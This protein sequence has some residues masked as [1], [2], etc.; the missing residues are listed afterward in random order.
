MKKFLPAILVLACLVVAAV[1]LLHRSKT[2]QRGPVEEPF[3]TEPQAVQA[4]V[5]FPEPPP[6]AV[7]F[8]MKYR[9]LSGDKDEFRYNSYY[10]YGRSGG[11]DAPFIKAVGKRA[12]ELQAVYNPQLKGAEWSAVELEDGKAVAFHFDLNA[13]GKV[14]D[15][16][17]I[18]PAIVEEEPIRR[19]EF[20]T[21]DFTTETEDGHK[22]PFRVL[23][24]AE[25]YGSS[26]S[27]SCMWSP[28][29]VL[30]G[31]S[32]ID[33]EPAKLILYTGGFSGSFT[34]FGR[35][36]YSLVIGEEE[37]GRHISRQTL[38]S[39]INHDGQFYHVDLY[40]RHG[41]DSAVRAVIR[42][43][44]G[45][46]GNLAVAL[47]SDSKLKSRLNGAGIEGSKDNTINFRVSTD[48]PVLPTGTYKLS[49]ANIEYGTEDTGQWWVGL[50][51]GPEFAVA[52][53]KRSTLEFGKP[54][55]SVR[56]VDEEKRY[57]SDVKEQ[58]TYSKGTAVYL[59]RKITGKAGE[60]YGRF[61]K[62]DD[63][64]NK[65]VDVEPRIKIVDSEGRE[66]ASAKMEYG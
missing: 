18:L 37:I 31:T 17:R 28:S 24:R 32:T 47:A 9:G 14:S 59:S 11:D 40:G 30:D 62:K 33:G 34:K 12:E 22:A 8:D 55:L 21:P 26:S 58:S 42:K 39:I 7:V 63:S 64:S 52:S 41:R 66:V 44:A 3:S 61:S 2:E 53:E 46:T 50:T 15:D 1:Y 54:I 48:Q 57:H 5:D 56:A 16:E 4:P 23:L 19:T 6:G 10:G 13:D 60:L 20:V 38:S 25:F 49:S 35:C 36:A 51:E 27:P 45:A 29:C 43:Y 65:L